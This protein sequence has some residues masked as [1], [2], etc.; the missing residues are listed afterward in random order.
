MRLLPYSVTDKKCE[1]DA[2]STGGHVHQSSMF[3]V[4]A[5]VADEGGRICSHNTARNG[6]LISQIS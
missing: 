2:D 1:E 4:I 6:Q 3:S 5:N